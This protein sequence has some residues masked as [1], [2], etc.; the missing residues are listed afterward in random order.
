MRINKYWLLLV[1]VLMAVL[2]IFTACSQTTDNDGGDNDTIDNP[3]VRLVTTN[4]VKDSGLLTY[5]QP[6]FEEATGYTLEISAYSPS[7]AI[8]AGEEGEADCLLLHDKSAEKDFITAGYGV[9]RVPF[10]DSYYLIV[11]PVD[12][13]AGI[14]D[15]PSA[16]AAFTKIASA[17]GT[18][19]VSR[20][21]GSELFKAEMNIWTKANINPADQPWY[22]TTS[23]DMATTLNMAGERQAY[24]LTD[25][26]TY[27]ANAANLG[28]AILLEKSDDLKNTYTL[29]AVDPSA[30]P[31]ANNAGANAFIEWMTGDQASQLIADYGVK[32]YGQS[33]FYT[34]DNQ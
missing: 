29:I 24:C 15:S 23:A 1:V 31:D 28:L 16:A 10:M 13:P 7:A 11:G 26:T 17:S 22:F 27:L 30:W 12:D 5:L 9:E 21:D 4:T 25:K 34:I 2:L 32:D 3:V 14:S 20:G 6:Y 8:S 33:L 19:F 18:D